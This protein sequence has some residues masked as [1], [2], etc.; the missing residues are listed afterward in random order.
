MQHTK[1]AYV[2]RLLSALT[3]LISLVACNQAAPPG[4]PRRP[5][6][7]ATDPND[8]LCIHSWRVTAGDRKGCGSRN[9][10]SSRHSGLFRNVGSY[11]LWSDFYA[12]LLLSD[13]QD[14]GSK[15]K[16]EREKSPI[17]KATAEE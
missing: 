14:G 2:G 3:G 13:Q 5:V 15:P 1:A 7:A 16:R 12:D 11:I 9:G 4:R 10:P 17:R 8:F 6:A